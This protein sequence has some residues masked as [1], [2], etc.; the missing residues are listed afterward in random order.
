METGN[1]ERIQNIIKNEDELNPLTD[2]EIAETLN[3]LRE[4]VTNLRKKMGIPNSRERK[5][6][7]LAKL[8]VDIVSRN[9]E[10][11]S[12][13]IFIALKKFDP[14][15]TVSHAEELIENLPVYLEKYSLD[16]EA[17]GRENTFSKLIGFDKSLVKSIK[18]AKA[19]ILYPPFGLSTLIV[20][21]S[22]TGK[23]LFADCMYD[24]AVNNNVIAGDAPYITLNCAD[25]ADNP[26]LLLSILYGYKKGSFTGAESDAPGLV[27]KADNGVLF[28]DEVHRLPPEGQEI[29]FTLLDKGKYRRLG[30]TYNERST[31][32]IF[33]CATT[34]N[35]ESSLLVS[36][37]RRINMIIDI[38]SLESRSIEEKLELVCHFFQEECN[39]TGLKIFVDSKVL[40][41]FLLKRYHGNI[42]Q[43]KSEV[44]V[45]CA[46]AYVENL[47]LKSEE[48]HIGLNEIL[49][50]NIFSESLNFDDRRILKIKSLVNNA[51]FLPNRNSRKEI[52]NKEISGGYD[53]SR[54]IY[55]Q[56]E[57][58]YFEIKKLDIG[59]EETKNILWTYVLNAFNKIET[60]STEGSILND[61][62]IESFVDRKLLNIIEEFIYYLKNQENFDTVNKNI[63]NHL[64]IHIHEALQRIRYK[65][66][67]I[68][69]NLNKIKSQYQVEYESARKLAELLEVEYSLGIPDDEVGFIAMYL[70]AMKQNEAKDDRIGVIVLSHG[71]VASEMIVV[72][73]KLMN[74]DFP[75]A[76]DMPLSENPSKIFEKTIEMSKI[77][78]NGNGILF[79]SDMGSL[80]NIGDIVTKRTGIKTRTVDKVDIVTLID[81]VRKVYLSEETLDSIYFNIIN[82]R[83]AL[84]EP[85]YGHDRDKP[86]IIVAACLTGHGM[87]G[88]IKQKIREVDDKVQVISMG[89]MSQDMKE[90]IQNLKERFNIIAIVGTINPEVEG[91]AYIQ[92]S[93]ELINSKYFELMINKGN[94][95]G[96]KKALNKDFILLNK[97]YDSKDKL[98]E[99]AYSMLYNKGYVQKEYLESLRQRED[100]NTTFAKGGVAIPHGMPVYVNDTVLM[101][102]KLK[103]EMTWDQEG[104][105]VDIIF[106]PVVRVNDIK[107]INSLIRIVKSN[108][109][110]EEI[111]NQ[112]T[113]DDIYD[114]LV[115]KIN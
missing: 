86:S 79:F 93:E 56:I 115:E 78:D 76:I 21:E 60:G 96:K 6:E 29:L 45:T 65:H 7:A 98:L 1:E 62:K 35:I 42:G 49:Y 69:P 2:K 9:Q 5:K 87:A 57:D 59:S 53:Y 48:I 92:Y 11:S 44:K 91:V 61:E 19:S 75:I 27:E 64:C 13:D 40:E 51:V 24:F 63:L 43:L 80:V 73:N 50:N 26:Q 85:E 107:L 84:T 12:D 4:T 67:I 46:N 103:K 95:D 39:R 30:E 54:D 41:A 47:N 77:I 52:I 15:I 31:K 102:I 23:T 16:F 34:E 82:S 114:L 17:V 25:Y 14:L 112:T 105:K 71:R 18:H 72:V 113:K 83:Y 3:V 33:I 36:F 97:T 70:K 101:V 110:L 10:I 104:R 90:E 74:V 66:S 106:M 68:N 38:P 37:R 28:L 94:I 88:I 99:D 32:V 111:R 89:M 8:V 100:M 58:K 81:A 55:H 20:G 22:G 108:E 109:I